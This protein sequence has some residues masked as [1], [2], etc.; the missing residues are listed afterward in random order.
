MVAPPPDERESLEQD[1]ALLAHM[2]GQIVTSPGNLPIFWRNFAARALTEL[3][4]REGREVRRFLHEQWRVN[5][6]ASK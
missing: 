4:S 6:R 3:R 2:M 5:G 1:V